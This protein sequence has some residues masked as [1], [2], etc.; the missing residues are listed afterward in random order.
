MTQTKMGPNN[1]PKHGRFLLVAENQTI[2]VFKMF[3]GQVAKAWSTGWSIPVGSHL[4]FVGNEPYKHSV[5]LGSIAP[6][7]NFLVIYIYIYVC[8]YIYIY[9]NMLKYIGSSLQIS[10]RGIGGQAPKMGPVVYLGC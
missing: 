8:T 3:P 6:F 2:L 1:P 5:S 4:Q 9:M 7:V 10:G